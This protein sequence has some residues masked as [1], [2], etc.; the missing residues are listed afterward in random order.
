MFRLSEYTEREALATDSCCMEGSATNVFFIPSLKNEQR[1]KRLS[2]IFFS[3]E[4]FV[5]QLFH[6]GIM[7]DAL[8]HTSR[9]KMIFSSSDVSFD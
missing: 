5:N 8:T 4:L 6:V 9:G 3:R 2:I 7:K 1:P